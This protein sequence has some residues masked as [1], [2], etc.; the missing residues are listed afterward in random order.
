MRLC[1]EMCV[2]RACAVGVWCVFRRVDR[3]DLAAAA[4]V[5]LL[6]RT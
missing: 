1:E 5:G 3:S 4:L 6:E 2:I